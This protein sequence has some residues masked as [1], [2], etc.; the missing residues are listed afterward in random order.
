MPEL[1]SVENSSIPLFK[2]K[3]LVEQVMEQTE[4]IKSNVTS[5]MYYPEFKR[6][7]RKKK[8][9]HSKSNLQLQFTFHV[10]IEKGLRG[11]KV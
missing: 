9:L 4:K 3:N 6:Q 10:H 1:L 11:V 8:L 2:V 7:S 5:T